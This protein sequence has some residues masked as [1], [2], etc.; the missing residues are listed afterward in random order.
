MFYVV[1][2]EAEHYGQMEIQPAQERMRQLVAAADL[3]SLEGP[4]AVTLM[5]DGK[6][7]I[8]AGAL[9]YWKDRALVWSFLSSRVGRRNMAVVHREAMRFLD[10][11]P[12]R[13]LE[14]SV[15]VGFEQGH[16]WMKM[17]GFEVEAPLQRRFQVDGTDC[18]G[19]VRI[20][21]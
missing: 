9:L 4:Y 20:R 19:Y 15:D 3:K 14:A 13:R 1:P 6:P 8:C 16:R 11:L 12:I 10:A 5:D 2:F 17:L 7:L 21:G 18:V